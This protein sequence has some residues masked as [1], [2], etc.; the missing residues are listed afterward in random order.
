MPWLL[1]DFNQRISF[2]P[3]IVLD[4]NYTHPDPGSRLF[5]R[6]FLRPSIAGSAR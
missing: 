4:A 2:G 3:S 1:D 6:L 5:R